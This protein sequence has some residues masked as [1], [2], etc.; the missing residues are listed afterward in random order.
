[1][2][3]LISNSLKIYAFDKMPSEPTWKPH[4]EPQPYQWKPKVPIMKN[5]PKTSVQIVKE[6]KHENVT[7]WLSL[8]LL[9]ST[10]KWPKA[11]IHPSSFS[12]MS[13][14]LPFLGPQLVPCPPCLPILVHIH[15]HSSSIVVWFHVS[16]LCSH[17]TFS[18]TSTFTFDILIFLLP[19]S[20]I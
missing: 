12:S 16:T 14:G 8:H 7:L 20:L 6:K 19:L 17:W 3:C 9:T 1:M 5:A 10:L 11:H 18:P 4:E 13:A 15:I 2:S